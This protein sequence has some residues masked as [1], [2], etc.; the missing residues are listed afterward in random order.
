MTMIKKTVITFEIKDPG[1]FYPKKSTHLG[2]PEN[3]NWS[4]KRGLFSSLENKENNLS[5]FESNK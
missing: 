1:Y 4:F 5:I 2:L 3:F